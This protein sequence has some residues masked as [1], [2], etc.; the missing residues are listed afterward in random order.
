MQM[1]NLPVI[2]PECQN[3]SPTPLLVTVQAQG[4]FATGAQPVIYNSTVNP[5]AQVHGLI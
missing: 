4:S 1:S 3:D 2:Q 5:R